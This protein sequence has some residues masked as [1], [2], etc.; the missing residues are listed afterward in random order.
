MS[1]SYRIREARAADIQTLIAFTLQEAQEAEHR[2]LDRDA[3]ARGVRQAFEDPPAA[4]YWVAETDDGRVAGSASIVTEWSNFNGGHY[5]WVQ[6]LFIAPEDRGKGLVERLLD[7]LA[8]V[9]S[10]A[11]ALDLRLYAHNANERALRVYR[12]SGFDEAP[13]TIMRRTLR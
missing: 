6:S 2:A 13:Y 1:S 9:A 7:H 3:V 12:R 11:G 8:A 10:A 4:R 5:W